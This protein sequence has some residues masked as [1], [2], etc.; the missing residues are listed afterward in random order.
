M[1]LRRQYERLLLSPSDIQAS[2]DDFEV[3]GVFNPGAIVA[4]GEVVLLVRVAER[5]RECRHGYVALPR[6][7]AEDGVVIDWL[8]DD[9]V[10]FVDPRVV[11]RKADGLIRLTFISHIRVVKCGDGRA[12]GILRGQRAAGRGAAPRAGRPRCPGIHLRGQRLGF[13]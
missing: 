1:L 2:R 11:K 8:A 5:P 4:D 3:V 6:W 10:E 7:S 12:V 9:V 13:R